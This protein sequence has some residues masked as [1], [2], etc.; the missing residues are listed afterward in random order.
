MAETSNIQKDA[1]RYKAG[2]HM[3]S[4]EHYAYCDNPRCNLHSEVGL[5]SLSVGKLRQEMRDSGWAKRD[6]MDLCPSCTDEHDKAKRKAKRDAR[7][8]ETEQ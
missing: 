1:R 6:G 5:E 4:S 2:L 8:R 3:I 7:Q